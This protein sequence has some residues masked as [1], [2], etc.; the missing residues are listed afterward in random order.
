[1][2][3]DANTSEPR[4]RLSYDGITKTDLA[5]DSGEPEAPTADPTPPRATW[6]PV[7]SNLWNYAPASSAGLG[8][9]VTTGSWQDIGD[10]GGGIV[11]PGVSAPF[12][13]HAVHTFICYASLSAVTGQLRLK[14]VDSASVLATITSVGS[15][16]FYSSNSFTLPTIDARYRLECTIDS[17]SGTCTVYH[18]AWWVI[19]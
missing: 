8:V 12:P 10:E 7:I 15:A 5:T 4:F 18:A 3:V 19:Y 9:A 17:G 13:S 16:G 14:D 2:E 6:Q 11:V 1:M